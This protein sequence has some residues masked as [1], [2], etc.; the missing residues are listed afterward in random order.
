MSEKQTRCPKCS[1]VYK[2][3]LS[4]LS[5]AQGMVCCPKC[6][7]NFNALTNLL[8]TDS[9]ATPTPVNRSLFS[10][11][12]PDSS[13]AEKQMQILRIFDQKIE[14]SN[15]DL[16]TYL[17]NLNYFNTEPVTALPN[18]NLSEDALLIEQENNDKQHGWLY[19][20]LWGIGNIALILVFAFQILWFNP[21][22][23]HESPALN[24]MFNYVCGVFNCKISNEQYQSLSFEKVK[25]KRVEQD[26]TGFSGVLLNQDANSVVLPPIKVVLKQNGEAIS[27][28]VLKPQD[29]LVDSLK[30]IQRIPSNSPFRFE[31]TIPKSKN[32]FNDYSLEFVQ[33]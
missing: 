10:S 5:V 8:E 31:F 22:L 3:T 29:Y 33:P 9:E 6:V 18:L 27:S 13:F 11:I 14:N 28:T 25:L 1:T 26:A 32:S 4:Q 30:T 17:N 16:L 19:Y 7:I 20:T 24:Q 23:M 15:I 21:K 2:V 12:Q